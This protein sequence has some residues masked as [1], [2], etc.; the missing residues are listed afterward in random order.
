MDIV[1]IWRHTK[2]FDKANNLYRPLLLFN[3]KV[4]TYLLQFSL[5]GNSSPKGVH[6]AV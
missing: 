1:D 6:N 4:Y 3:S 2:G 5:E